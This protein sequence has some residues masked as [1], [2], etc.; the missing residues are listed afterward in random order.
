MATVC[1]IRMSTKK[2]DLSP[3]VQKQACVE[4]ADRKQ[5][6][7]IDQFF[8]DLGRSGKTPLANRPEGLAMLRMLRRDDHV[9][10]AKMDRLGRNGLDITNAVHLLDKQGVTVHIVDYYGMA[11]ID[12]STAFGRLLLSLEAHIC[13]LER[14]QIAKRTAETKQYQQTGLSTNGRAPLGFRLVI[15]EI[16]GRSTKCIEPDP[17]ERMWIDQIV[18]WITAGWSLEEIYRELCRKHAITNAGVPWTRKRLKKYFQNSTRDA[19]IQ[20]LFGHPALQI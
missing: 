11:Q 20:R 17:N 4:Y 5:I 8:A 19:T 14:D 7:P 16:N 13:E 3:E 6:D 12:T 15:K 9:V 1:Y 2:Q 10:V 18:A